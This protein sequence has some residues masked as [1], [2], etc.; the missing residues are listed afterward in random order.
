MG[1]GQISNC[2][3]LYLAEIS[4]TAIRG[5]TVG[6][7]QL[8]L[9]IGQV[10][11]A[12]VDQGTQ[13]IPNS[14]SYRIPIGLNMVIPLIVFIFIA[15][16]PESPHWLITKRGKDA[17]VKRSLERINKSQPGYTAEKDYRNLKTAHEIATTEEEGSW[18]QVFADPI[19]RR[20]ACVRF[21]QAH[22][23][24]SASACLAFWCVP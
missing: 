23:T 10:I 5:I 15:F 2:V 1:I 8:L 24:R 22:L 7:W 3:P 12:G 9:A 17:Q 13:G 11:G 21:V 20:K 19:E 14:A 18:R 6:S 16:V 4:N